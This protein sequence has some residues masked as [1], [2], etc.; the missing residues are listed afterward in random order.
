MISRKFDHYEAMRRDEQG[1]DRDDDGE[2][3]EEADFLEVA[4]ILPHSNKM[5]GL[6]A[7]PSRATLA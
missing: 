5:Q 1:I 2:L 3:I 4:H 6:R 7:I